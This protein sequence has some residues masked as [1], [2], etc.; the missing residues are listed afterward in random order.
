MSP[1]IGSPLKAN[2]RFIK[3]VEALSDEVLKFYFER[4]YS[5]QL[6]DCVI[7]PMPSHILEGIKDIKNSHYSQKPVGCG[8]F[9]IEEYRKGDMLILR[10]SNTFF[11]KTPF[12]SEVVF[13][14]YETSYDLGEALKM[15]LV[16]M[17][18][19][20]DPVVAEELVN[21]YTQG[22]IINYPG[23]R[24]I[25][26]GFNLKR[27]PFNNL[28][29]RQVF[30]KALRVEEWINEVFKGYAEKAISIF[31][32]ALWAFD[33]TLEELQYTGIEEIDSLLKR[34]GYTRKKPLKI[35]LIVEKVQKEHSEIAE[36]IKN[37][38]EMSKFVKVQLDTLGSIEFLQR[39]LGS[40]FDVYILS[41]S[42]TEKA[43]VTPLFHSKGIFNF[44]G[45]IN[46]KVDEL[47]EKAL[48]TLNRNRA[49]KYLSEFQ[50]I[51]LTELPVLPLIVPKSII[52]ISSRVKG[53]DNYVGDY[54]FSNLDL[55]WVPEKSRVVRET[56]EIKKEEEELK[57]EKIEEKPI[58]K[59]KEKKVVKE[60]VPSPPEVP[61]VTAE[62]LLK[63]E[64]VEREV[65]KVEEKKE[66]K[67]EEVAKKEPIPEKKP[68]ETKPKP[69]EKIKTPMLPAVMPKLV[70]KVEPEYPEMARKLGAKGRVFLRVLINREGEVSKVVVLRSS[71]YDF[72]DEA[73]KEAVRKYKFIPAKDKDGNPIE[74]WHPVEVRF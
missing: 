37:T 60:P 64:L 53:W 50:R 6:L 20:I 49:K 1:E 52:A 11:E 18:L 2:F 68:E 48:G 66:E 4:T 7:Y 55:F 46:P 51:I 40:D 30:A 47:I 70:K 54:M 25:F 33:S 17:A 56:Y 35:N 28:E 72:L 29:F 39:L 45:Y 67:V 19:D 32:Q 69:P 15:D 73:A 44:G 36:K 9:V 43:D 27:E 13:K 38:W 41:W 61:K 63:R 16:D 5:A 74:V 65:E 3:K 58:V 14:I 8:P 12:V 26:M 10:K 21:T 34:A 57:E 59:R 71:G 22:K 42:V 24:V 62:E 31:S 23:R